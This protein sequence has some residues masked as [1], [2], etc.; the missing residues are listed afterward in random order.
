MAVL[1]WA[2]CGRT[3]PGQRLGLWRAA[4]VVQSCSGKQCGQSI[5]HCVSVPLSH[6]ATQSF[7]HSFTRSLSHLLFFVMPDECLILPFAC[8]IVFTVTMPHPP[9]SSASSSP[10][11]VIQSH[12]SLSPVLFPTLVLSFARPSSIAL[13]IVLTPPLHP[14]SASHSHHF[15]SL[16]TSAYFE[17]LLL[18]LI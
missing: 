15:S 10:P 6:R 7:A 17:A 9:H 11:Y 14:S 16:S 13:P 4:V 2:P 18:D 5:S 1:L 12:L 8:F 3:L